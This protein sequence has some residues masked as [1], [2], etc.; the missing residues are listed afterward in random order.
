MI[1]K[2]IAGILVVILL[3]GC[4]SR[5]SVAL[6]TEKDYPP[7]DPVLVEVFQQ[8]PSNRK[9][10]EIGEVTVEY[11]ESWETV[12][13]VFKDKAAEVGGEAVYVIDTKY[14]NKAQ[15]YSTPIAYPGY[16]DP[17]GYHYGY[18]RRRWGYRYNYPEGFYTESQTLITAVGVIIRYTDKD[19]MK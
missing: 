8:K 2:G 6:Y 9:F 3:E 15:Y 7:T 1:N 10:V 13:R 4:A 12:R 18:G 11:A 19:Q 14:L 17:Y 16:Y 5:G